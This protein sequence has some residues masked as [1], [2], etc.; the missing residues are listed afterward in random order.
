MTNS[1]SAI[2]QADLKTAMK[3]QEPVE[4]RT[5]R[6]LKAALMSKELEKGRGSLS[7]EDALAVIQKQARQRRESMAQYELA[8]RSD[9][10]AKEQEELAV[11]ETYLPE[12]LTVDELEEIVRAAVSSTG[13]ASPADM[14]K[15]MGIVMPTVKGR[16][17]G[18][19]V[20]EL[21]SKTLAQ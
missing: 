1:I 8:G 16:A 11:I 13:A 20:R 18:N 19:T 21:V 15:V 10:F 17:D 14:G 6:G 5:L 12:D 3:A 2:L 7:D 9:L 4:I